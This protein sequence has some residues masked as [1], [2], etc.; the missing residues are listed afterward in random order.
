MAHL[1][2]TPKSSTIRVYDQPNGYEKRLPYVGIVSIDHLTD[3][4]VYIH[5]AV[6]KID[7]ETLGQAYALLRE[8]G[9]TTALVERHRQVK[10]IRLTS[11]AL[12]KEQHQE[13][14]ALVAAQLA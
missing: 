3:W 9:V 4:L 8:Q 11:G 1:K 10:V 7:R 14:Q 2:L 6:G 5:G 12:P 13:L